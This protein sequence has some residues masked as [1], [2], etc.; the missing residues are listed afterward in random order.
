MTVT[1]I[2]RENFYFDN[3]VQTISLVLHVKQTIF[4]K[5]IQQM[6]GILRL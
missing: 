1:L 3:L 6:I 2:G 4:Y 5:Y